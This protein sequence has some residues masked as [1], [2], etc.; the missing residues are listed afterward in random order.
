MASHFMLSFRD[1]PTC[2]QESEEGLQ[3]QCLARIQQRPLN[4]TAARWWLPF[5]WL[6]ALGGSPWWITDFIDLQ[7][8]QLSKSF[9][10]LISQ[11]FHGPQLGQGGL[12]SQS[13]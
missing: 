13:E 4:L 9:S 2:V 1:G 5:W 6:P 8:S 11:T 10:D 7:T 12:D 3:P